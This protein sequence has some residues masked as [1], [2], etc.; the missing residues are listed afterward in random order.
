M[1]IGRKVGTF[2]LEK[3]RSGKEH[4]QKK[5]EAYQTEKTFGIE[6]TRLYKLC[7]AEFTALRLCLTLF[8]SS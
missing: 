8:F 2:T 6:V 5:R 4:L 1:V 7:F 3:E